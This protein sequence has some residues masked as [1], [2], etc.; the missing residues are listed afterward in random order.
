MLVVGCVNINSVG[1]WLCLGGG[2]EGG[3]GVGGACGSGVGA[4]VCSVVGTAFEDCNTNYKLLLYC[5]EPPQTT[6]F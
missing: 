1:T 2:S 3:A 6:H 4:G 5:L